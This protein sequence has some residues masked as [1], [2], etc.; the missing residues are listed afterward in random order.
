MKGSYSYFHGHIKVYD[1]MKNSDDIDIEIK[2]ITDQIVAN[3]ANDEKNEN[4]LN[5]NRLYQYVHGHLRNYQLKLSCI[6]LSNIFV[7]ICSGRLGCSSILGNDPSCPCASH[8]VMSFPP[9]H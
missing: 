6:E 9:L 7:D 2:V 5:I 4:L 8:D 3:N 1:L